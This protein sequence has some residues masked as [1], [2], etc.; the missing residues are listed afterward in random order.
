MHTPSSYAR[1]G[2][3]DLE[4]LKKRKRSSA[5]RSKS[6]QAKAVKPKEVVNLEDEEETTT[7]EVARVLAALKTECE[8]RGRVNYF[9]FLVN[10]D[11]FAHT[12][13]NMFHFSFLVKDGRAGVTVGRDGLP[14]VFIRES[15]CIVKSMRERERE[16]EV[17]RLVC[18]LRS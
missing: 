11:S 12:V 15:F 3:L 9:K 16:R 17:S 13:E 7:K 8:A 1:L 5:P 18:T 4:P 2:A 10:P 6:Q 14:Y